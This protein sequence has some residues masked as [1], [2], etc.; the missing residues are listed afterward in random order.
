MRT[1]K[2][3][4]SLLLAVA[5]V[6]SL[7]VV[8]ASAYENK[9][10]DFGD[11]AE[12]GDEYLEAV[13]VMSGLGI[14]EGYDDGNFKPA[15][16]YTREQAAKIIA[17][18]Q[19][20][21]DAA[22]KL[23]CTVSPFTD[24]DAGRWSA[25]YI[26]YAKDAGILD[27]MGDGS[28]DPTGTLTGFQWAKMLLCAVGY[29]ENGEFTGSEWSI[30]TAK[31]AQTVKLFAGD[32]TG[33]T[34]GVI[35]REQAVLYA[36][37]TLVNLGVVVYSPAL[38]DYIF[39]YN[40][41]I[42]DRVT[43]EGT[44]GWN[45]Y[46]L[47][48]AEGIIVD[49]EGMG[50]SATYLASNYNYSTGTNGTAVAKINADTDIDM[51][52]H[53]ARIWYVGDDA[54]YVNDL[55]SVTSYTCYES[56]AEGDAAAKKA[57]AQN[58]DI[59][60]GT[61]YEFYLIDNS[62]VA[63]PAATKNFAYVTVNASLGALGY[64]NT[65]AKT[66]RVAGV[67]VPNAKILTDISEIDDGDQIVY[68]RTTSRVESGADKYAY[69]VYPVSYT[70]GVVQ[71]IGKTS[72]TLAD[73]TVLPASKLGVI[74]DIGNEVIIGRNYTFMLDNHGDFISITRSGARELYYFTGEWRYTTPHDVYGWTTVCQ[75]INVTTGEIIERTVATSANPTADL[76]TGDYYDLTATA[77]ASGIYRA[78]H[79][80][81]TNSPY[82]GAY[83]V[84]D[85]SFVFTRISDRITGITG[86]SPIYF[87]R[88][89][90]TFIVVTR[91]G[92]DPQ[93]LTATG[94]ADLMSKLD[95]ASNG[96][97]QLTNFAVTLSST[98][99]GGRQADVIFAAV[100]GVQ[101]QSNYVFVPY[102]I[103]AGDWTS[104]TGDID[105]YLVSYDGGA[106]LDGQKFNT[107]FIA[108]N[109]VTGSNPSNI[110]LERGF[111][112]YT[113]GNRGILNLTKRV[114]NTIPGGATSFELCYYS[115]NVTVDSIAGTAFELDGFDVAD[116]VVI[117]DLRAASTSFPAIT[118][119]NMQELWRQKQNDVDP[120]MT[121]GYTRNPAT[122]EVDFI[123]V[124]DAGWER[125]A[126]YSLSD[127]LYNAG[128]RWTGNGNQ[129][130]EGKDLNVPGAYF[131]SSDMT[132]W[133]I[134]NIN[135]D[136]G[137]VPGA[138]YTGTRG[139]FVDYTFNGTTTRNMPVDATVTS[140]NVLT[141]GTCDLPELTDSMTGART[142]TVTVKGL[143]LDVQFTRG[144]RSEGGTIPAHDFFEV[145]SSDLNTGVNP[146][147]TVTLGESVTVTVVK[148]SGNFSGNVVD[149]GFTHYLDGAA[150]GY[151]A[152]NI[153]YHNTTI[154]NSIS[155]E[156]TPLCWGTY[157]LTNVTDNVPPTA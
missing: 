154:G 136:L 26:A 125:L 148:D 90:V 52:Y 51:M 47:K 73:G 32:L 69:H 95:V 71:S 85:N 3:T 96:T 21:P 103:E 139:L 62:A 81:E 39:S 75:F 155:F 150:S 76:V 11:V 102:T 33:M 17:Y 144:T 91:T 18:M 98:S 156:A 15:T 23:A 6:L 124:V 53:G 29:G 64:K 153:D 54:V 67:T 104:I 4:L 79:V 2:K 5:L 36:F 13:G 107:F 61:E 92:D 93:M 94:V 100:A 116:D 14:I 110:V 152:Y 83:A 112:T 58:L 72:I 130:Y 1:L 133:Q 141:F 105:G 48:S 63:V 65:V 137:L 68:I 42:F 59:G 111:Y 35:N 142:I 30:N 151:T 50:A 89:N 140:G 145:Y 82:A 40:D 143:E 44:L 37:N 70:S 28:F 149:I 38:G 9:V 84:E 12:I 10:D 126:V 131:G 31:V 113:H 119:N 138:T 128:W 46:K 80:T 118:G 127:E 101:A 41:K 123:Y 157:L 20:G 78:T 77:N 129:I 56:D 146:K 132:G 66:T 108:G 88:D 49:N 117:T 106:Y 122:G 16:S 121:I 34:N 27:G 43:Y 134:T 55:A 87:D 24:V 7:T 22:E 60:S 120:D 25:G 135:K 97:V 109:A 147:G 74:R 115:T 19:L 114:E 57:D 99:T 45:V 8:G 86:A